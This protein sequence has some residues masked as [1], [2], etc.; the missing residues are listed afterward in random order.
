VRT[1]CLLL[2]SALA[3]S[4]CT[5]AQ[6]LN[7]LTPGTGY[8]LATNLPFDDETR[9]RL[10]VYTPAGEVR[11]A[12]VVVFF[13]GGR[14]T[15]GSKDDFRF[16]GQALAAQGFVA[17]IAD[18]RKYPD[19]VFPVFVEDAARAVRWTHR[20]IARFGGS[21]DKLFVMGHSSGAH[22]AAMLALNG[23]YLK[24][25][26]GS[27]SWLKGMIGLAGP[28]DFMPITAPDLRD[29]FDPPERFPD[30]QPIFFADGQNPPLL[31]MHGEDDEDVWVKNTRNLAKAV[32]EAGGGVET[33]IYPKLGHR[34]IIAAISAPLRSRNDVISHIREFV[35][36]HA[37]A[38][39]REPA[40]TLQTRPLTQP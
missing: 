33:V 37:T 26:G 28:Y 1:F 17:V 20:N 8:V 6:V 19:V 11:D 38:P 32:G 25:V 29:M 2:L 16:V 4:A 30:S 39:A 34:W 21:P 3:L 35:N 15:T 36:R 24:A 13:Y 18:H 9:L 10:D 22:L 40:P 23:E 5:G 7:S 31:L 14:W 27:R 12:P